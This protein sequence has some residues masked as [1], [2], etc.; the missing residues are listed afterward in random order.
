MYDATYAERLSPNV[1]A[2]L[3]PHFKVVHSNES[4]SGRDKKRTIFET[5]GKPYTT[6]PNFE[7]GV[8]GGKTKSDKS[9]SAKV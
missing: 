4:A 2:P 1:G 8:E 7:V 5:T 3:A 6:F 9:A